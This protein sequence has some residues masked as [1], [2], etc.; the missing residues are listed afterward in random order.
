MKT[1]RC[2]YS[3][4]RITKRL[5]RPSQAGITQDFQGMFTDGIPNS[6]QRG[7]GEFLYSR[8]LPTIIIICAIEFLY[9]VQGSCHTSL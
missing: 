4:K 3:P 1:V 9:S 5:Q 8:F 2:L 6:L 7:L